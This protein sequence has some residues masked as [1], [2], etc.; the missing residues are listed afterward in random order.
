MKR[1]FRRP[2]LLA[3]VLTALTFGACS[4]DNKEVPTP[5]KAEETV[6]EVDSITLTMAAG[7]FHGVKFH[8]DSDAEGIKHL[9][10]VQ[11]IR[12]K[13]V[14][15][16]WEFAKNSDTKFRVRS[17]SDAVQAA[18]GLWIKYYKNGKEVNGN[19]IENKANEQHQHFFIPSNVKAWYKGKTEADDNDPK[20]M[21][22]YIYMDTTPW[23]KTLNDAGTQLSG[24]KVIGADPKN[25]Q[26]SLFEMVDPIGFKGYF[27]F[28]RAYKE[29][30]LNIELLHAKAG[31]KQADVL[32]PYY[33][34]SA[35]LRLNAKTEIKITVPVVVYLLQALTGEWTS[36]SE[37][38][39][40]IADLTEVEKHIVE[41]TAKA[42]GITPEEAMKEYFLKIEGKVED[43]GSLWF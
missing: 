24:S 30:D 19:F 4:S 18:Y 23:D 42:Y 38:V 40:S 32:S 21:F 43:N 11:V 5:P 12:L 33:K 8:Q 3:T 34:P 39:K 16:K 31:K 10:A 13:L 26:R 2:I 6:E 14:G 28:A 36:D 17:S 25:K 20:N 37:N 22:T 9:R 1:N 27:E 15:G 35:G 41:T 29:F 7:H